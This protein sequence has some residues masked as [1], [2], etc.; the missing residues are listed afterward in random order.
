MVYRVSHQYPPHQPHRSITFYDI[1]EASEE[2]TT[3][4]RQNRGAIVILWQVEYVQDE[5]GFT[6]EY[7]TIMQLVD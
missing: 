3:I 4:S 5:Y 6:K 7:A 1:D 2:F